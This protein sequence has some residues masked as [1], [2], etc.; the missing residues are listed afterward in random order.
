MAPK[1]KHCTTPHCKKLVGHIGNC[2]G[3]EAQTFTR[4][5]TT[6]QK[7]TYFRRPPGP[8]PRDKETHV[9]K[10][11]NVQLGKWI[12]PIISMEDQRVAADSLVAMASPTSG[13]NVAQTTPTTETY[14][15]PGP[16]TQINV[17]AQHPHVPQVVSQPV[18]AQASSFTF[19]LQQL[20]TQMDAQMA[21]FVALESRVGALETT[22]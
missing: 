6:V 8:A 11:W 16:H 10:I 14:V 3:A 22:A 1:K 9:L 12:T 19:L 20:G 18:L 4:R 7:K 21:R 2:S 5:P 15:P 13:L 17:Y